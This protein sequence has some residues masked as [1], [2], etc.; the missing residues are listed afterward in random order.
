MFN[1]TVGTRLYRLTAKPWNYLRSISLRDVLSIKLLCSSSRVPI[2]GSGYNPALRQSV[3]N[4]LKTLNKDKH[5]PELCKYMKEPEPALSLPK[6]TCWAPPP[7]TRRWTARPK[8]ALFISSQTYQVTELVNRSANNRIVMSPYYHENTI[9][10]TPGSES[11]TKP[12]Q[13]K[14][15]SLKAMPDVEPSLKNNQGWP[16]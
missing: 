4:R 16:L 2:I 7:L 10:P 14:R 11:S 6:I 9:T 12:E 3:W 8:P 15:Y 13:Q 5:V 1:I